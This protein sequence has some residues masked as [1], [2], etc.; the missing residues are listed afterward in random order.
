VRE[1]PFE[2]QRGYTDDDQIEIILPVGYTIE[3][4]PKGVELDSE[5]GYYKIDFSVIDSS[6]VIC[7]R[8]YIIKK[9][10]YESDKYEAFR[11]FKETIAKNDNSKIILTKL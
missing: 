3:A 2:I 5:F 8:K 11:K 1:F 4:M 7:K 6:K 10:F 9:G